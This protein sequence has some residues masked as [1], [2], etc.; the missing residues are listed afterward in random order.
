MSP[1]GKGE[2]KEGTSELD[3]IRW[4]RKRGR[5]ASAKHSLPSD[6]TA[7]QL[8]HCSINCQVS[9]MVAKND[10]N[11]ALLPTFRYVPNESP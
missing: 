2:T 9:N 4:D 5:R 8:L 1:T 11:L 3:R 7:Y 6:A 10:A